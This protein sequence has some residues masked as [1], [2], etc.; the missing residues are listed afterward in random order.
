MLVL[1]LEHLTEGGNSVVACVVELGRLD[2][3]CS[4]L[5]AGCNL[6]TSLESVEAILHEGT[7]S[8]ARVL[9]D[10]TNA[11]SSSLANACSLVVYE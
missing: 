5:F 4:N 11:V 2:F 1:E 3:L 6:N 7:E 10:H 8:R 9:S